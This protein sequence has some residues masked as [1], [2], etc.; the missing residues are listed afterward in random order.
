MADNFQVNSVFSRKAP[1]GSKFQNTNVVRYRSPKVTNSSNVKGAFT[2][3]VFIVLFMLFSTTI[4]ELPTPQNTT[5]QASTDYI[6]EIAPT[7]GDNSIQAISSFFLFA[8][9]LARVVETLVTGFGTIVN[10]ILTFFS[11]NWLTIDNQSAVIGSVCIAYNNLNTP[12]KAFVSSTY[13]LYRFAY[14]LQSPEYT[15][16]EQYWNFLQFRDYGLVCS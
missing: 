8:E 16:V 1:T 14:F 7:V 4:A 13:A 6:R 2:T 12:R 15:T 9:G 5:P 11:P 10:S 3:I